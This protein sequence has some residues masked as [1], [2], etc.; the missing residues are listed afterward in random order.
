MKKRIIQ[1]SNPDG[2]AP[3]KQV[4]AES[5]SSKELPNLVTVVGHGV[6]ASFELTVNGEIEAV[7]A[8]S[9]DLAS[10]HAVE[11]ATAS[12]TTQFRFSGELAN[13]HLFDKESAEHEGSSSATI[14]VEYGSY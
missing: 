12:G 14:H 7:G 4:A 13:A 9:I 11:G 1:E 5:P 3:K 6:P 10:N 2:M 8:E